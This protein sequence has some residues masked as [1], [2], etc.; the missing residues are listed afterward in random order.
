MTK[1]SI[2]TLSTLALTSLAMPAALLAEKAVQSPEK[3]NILF[4]LIDDMGWQDTSVPFWTEKTKFNEQYQ[5]PNMQRLADMGVTFTQSYSSP[6]CSPTRTSILTGETP[7]RHKVTN[8]T[9]RP[10]NPEEYEAYN[11]KPPVWKFNGIQPSDDELTMPEALQDLG[12]KTIHC[13]KAHWGVI[14]SPGE[15]PTNL[16]FDINIAGHAAGGPKSYYGEENFGNKKGEHTRP[17]GIPGLEKYHGT[18]IFLDQALTNEAMAAIDLAIAEEK[19]FYLYMAHY[20]IHSPF[21]AN[22]KFVQKYLDQG[23]NSTEAAYSSLIESMDD[24]LGQL[25]DHLEAKGVAENTIV[26]FSSDNGGPTQK[27][28]GRGKSIYG[29]TDTHNYPLREGKGSCYE[30]GVRVPTIIAPAKRGANNPP[31]LSNIAT[32]KRS[33]TLLIIEDMYPSFLSL[34]GFTAWD[35]IPQ[36]LDGTS[37]LPYLNASKAPESH[38]TRV[39]GAHFPHQWTRNLGTKTGY[40]PYTMVRKG[41]YKIIYFYRTKKWEMYNVSADIKEENNVAK[42]EPGK[43]KEMQEVFKNYLVDTNAQMPLTG[44]GKVHKIR[45]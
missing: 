12:Y 25:L 23:I 36:K 20:G 30:G 1:T 21:D 22:P 15:D 39:F 42:K 2:T 3:P 43:F 16:G 38:Q 31:Q 44:L 11:F 17:W 4:F 6:V 29:G 33:D 9:L 8:W 32:G 45:Y 10:D 13:G 18:D 41:D 7:A 5:T 26:I 35:T 28:G 14:D 40:Q 24:S 19:P 34:A 37:F 27:A